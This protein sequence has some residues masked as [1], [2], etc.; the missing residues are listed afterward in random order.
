LNPERDRRLLDVTLLDEIE[1]T[2]NLMI[3]ASDSDHALSQS[4]VDAALGL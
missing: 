2:T 3:A 1:M 4:Q